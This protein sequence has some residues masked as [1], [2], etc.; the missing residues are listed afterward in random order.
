[1]ILIEKET[2]ERYGAEDAM[3]ASEQIGLATSVKKYQYFA[4][5]FYDFHVCTWH[6]NQ[7]RIIGRRPF[8]Y[9]GFLF[10]ALNG[11]GLYY[12]VETHIIIRIE[13]MYK[14]ILIF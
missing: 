7:N 8:G 13:R 9:R 10:L 5:G 12:V 11:F 2:V 4:H 1:M 3:V 6:E 14:V